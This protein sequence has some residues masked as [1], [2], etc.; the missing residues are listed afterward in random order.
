MRGTPVT[1]RTLP[2]PDAEAEYIALEIQRQLALS[3]SRLNYA[4]VGI[5]L[6]FNALS[7]PI[8]A[9]LHR[10]GIPYRVVGGAKFFDRVEVKD[11]LAYMLLADNAS[12]TPAFVRIV[13]V[14]RRGIGPKSVQDI[15]ALAR[16]WNVPALTCAERL[17]DG[18]PPVE[19]FANV[20]T[21][22]VRALAPLV[23]SLRRLRRAAEE[24]VSMAELLQLVISELDY[25]SHLRREP[26]FESRW[27]NVQELINFAAVADQRAAESGGSPGGNQP[28]KEA[29]GGASID[30]LAHSPAAEAV[31]V[32]SGLASANTGQK[33]GAPETDVSMAKRARAEQAS[34]PSDAAPASPSPLRAFLENSILATDLASEQDTASKVTISTCHAAKGLEWPVVFVPAVENDTFPFYRS[35]SDEQQR[36]ERRL[37]YVAMTR[38]ETNLYLTSAAERMVAGEHMPRQLSPFVTQLVPMGR[39]GAQSSSAP[40]RYRVDWCFSSPALDASHNEAL[41]S[42]LG[43]RGASEEELDTCRKVFEASAPGL[44]LRAMQASGSQPSGWQS[45]TPRS[46]PNAGSTRPGPALGAGFLSAGRRE[47]PRSGYVSALGGTRPPSAATQGSGYVS[48]MGGTSASTQESGRTGGGSS[49]GFISALNSMSASA[50][51]RSESNQWS[52]NVAASGPGLHRG[53]SLGVRRMAPSGTGTPRL[54]TAPRRPLGLSR[55]AGWAPGS[56]PFGDPPSQD[57]RP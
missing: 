50:V 16:L 45:A 34:A 54:G 42:V 44:R 1:L 18:E 43:R 27:E 11:L 56:G 12:Y 52:D 17:V 10:A 3:A 26:D 55:P 13:N 33:R 48:A 39:G 40:P 22:T 46:N 19:G 14:P 2:D 25:E 23:E 41:V 57:E 5:L 4:D 30:D 53:K 32:P 49:A 31:S 36:E 47:K 29:T 20:R 35:R 8:E 7:R 21:A 9:A 24:R 6:R 38:A 37:L 15:I 28:A 51:G